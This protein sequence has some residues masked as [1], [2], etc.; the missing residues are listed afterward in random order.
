MDLFIYAKVLISQKKKLVC[1]KKS[2]SF[3]I[4]SYRLQWYVLILLLFASSL[5]LTHK[6]KRQHLMYRKNNVVTEIRFWRTTSWHRR[7]LQRHR[8]G[9]VGSRATECTHAHDHW[10]HREKSYHNKSHLSTFK[11]FTWKKKIICFVARNKS[12]P[13]SS[14]QTFSL[15]DAAETT[16]WMDAGRRLRLRAFCS[17]VVL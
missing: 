7:K 1:F 14:P 10:R 17:Q 4:I 5:L 13:S 9:A 16:A 8:D 11:Y 3:F 6:I 2:W 12:D 15:L